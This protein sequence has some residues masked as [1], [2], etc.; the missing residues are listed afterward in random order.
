[1]TTSAYSFTGVGE[2]AIFG[3]RVE[4]Y[5]MSELQYGFATAKTTTLS[6]WV[7]SSLTGTFGGSMNNNAANRFFPFQYTISSANTWE[8]KTV[9]IPGDITGTWLMSTGLGVQIYFSLGADST[10]KSTAGAWG[11]SAFIAPTSAVDVIS[12]LNAYLMITGVQWEAG[13]AA[14][15]FERRTQD[16]ELAAAQRYYYRRYPIDSTVAISGANNRVIA[17]GG[18]ISTTTAQVETRFPVTMRIAPTAL[19][20]SGTLGQYQVYAAGVSTNCSAVPTFTSAT[21]DSAIT[22]Y[23]VASGLTAGQV[24]FGRSNNITSSANGYLGWSAEI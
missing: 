14:T 13:R 20:Q 10:V 8:F 24:A 3:Q 1:V 23:T 2:Y 15:P 17:T 11:A 18:T 16:Q 19:E 4:A 5:N 22:T 12:T 6:F 9:V 21:Q 7:R